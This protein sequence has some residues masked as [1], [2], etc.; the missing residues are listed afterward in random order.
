M[1]MSTPAAVPAH[2]AEERGLWTRVIEMVMG[3]G[4]VTLRD[5]RARPFG[6]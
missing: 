5:G 3:L 2:R 6:G 1:R 4:W